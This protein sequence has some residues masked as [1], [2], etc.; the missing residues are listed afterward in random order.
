MRP[1]LTYVWQLSVPGR[2]PTPSAD[3]FSPMSRAGAGKFTT[4]TGE[5]C[6]LNRHPNTHPCFDTKVFLICATNFC[7]I[8]FFFPFWGGPPLRVPQLT[9]KIFSSSPTVFLKNCAIIFLQILTTR[10]QKQ[11][12]GYKFGSENEKKR[13][14]NPSDLL[15]PLS[16]ALKRRKTI[17][18]FSRA[19]HEF[20]R[21]FHALDF[22]FVLSFA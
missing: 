14:N 18:P 10:S 21:S 1:S 2:F 16:R 12:Q 9:R 11:I 15:H 8:V 13:D 19:I 17:F 3:P 4:D 20:S 6:V 5:S 22:P 7:C